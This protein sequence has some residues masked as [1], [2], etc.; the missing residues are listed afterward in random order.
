MKKILVAI[1]GSDA[2]RA[3][4]AVGLELAAEEG[5]EIV[6]AHVTSILDFATKLDDQGEVPPERVPRAEDDAVLREAVELANRVGV[7]AQPE[8]LVGYPSK[9][10]LRVASDV[11]AD[12]IVVGSRGLGR[13]KSAILGS[14]SR[15]VLSHADRPVLVVRDTAVRE[16]T[17]A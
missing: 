16:R 14:T 1:D 13:V 12:L 17:P 8:L 10:I 5:A 7:R 15:E 9:Q 6:F 11:G 3:A 4:V 2:A